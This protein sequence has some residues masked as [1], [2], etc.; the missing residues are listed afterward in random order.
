MRFPI[1]IDW[2][3]REPNKSCTNRKFQIEWAVTGEVRN[4]SVDYDTLTE[5]LLDLKDWMKEITSNGNEEELELFFHW[6]DSLHEKIMSDLKSA[7][8]GFDISFIPENEE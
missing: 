8:D 4:K 2:H 3:G 7:N 6:M 5:L 1:E